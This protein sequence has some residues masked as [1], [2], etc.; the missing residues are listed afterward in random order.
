MDLISLGDNA[1]IKLAIG[2]ERG[3]GEKNDFLTEHPGFI[4]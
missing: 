2:L 1:P 4:T 3:R